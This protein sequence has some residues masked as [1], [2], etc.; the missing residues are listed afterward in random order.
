MNKNNKKFTLSAIAVA[1]L[2]NFS[3]TAASNDTGVTVY[4]NYNERFEDSQAKFSQTGLSGE[5]P[6]LIKGYGKNIPFTITLDIVVPKHWEVSFNEGAENLLVNWQ[7]KPDGLAWPYVL[8]DLS[9]RNNVSVAIDWERKNVNFYAHEAHNDRFDKMQNRDESYVVDQAGEKITLENI[10]KEKEEYSRMNKILEQ[11]V[12]DR[13]AALEENEKLIA[14]MQDE[15][16]QSQK[17]EDLKENY[18]SGLVMNSTVEGDIATIGFEEEVFTEG[19]DI[20]LDELKEEYDN[21]TVLPIN[22]TFEFYKAGGWKQDI[23]FY[24]PA[25]YIAKRGETVKEVIESWASEIGW[26]VTY[27]TNVHYTIDYDIEFEGLAR[28][29]LIDLVSLY[30]DSK[31]PLDVK[32][33]MRQE[34]IEVDDLVFEKRKF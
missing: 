15:M 12:H 16:E 7:A 33:Y 21:R 10:L 32:F 2:V 24:T 34:L 22:K 3:A 19:L 30:K 13:K 9:K 25:T 23:D 18:G 17:E 14:K 11:E 28:E 6:K 1:V 20:S 27:D 8:E 4:E 5:M 26:E 29:A 31:R